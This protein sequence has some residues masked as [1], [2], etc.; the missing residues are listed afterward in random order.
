[1]RGLRGSCGIGHGR[2]AVGSVCT[3]AHALS[4]SGRG[5]G[6]GGCAGTAAMWVLVS[7]QGVWRGGMDVH[8]QG[9]STSGWNALQRALAPR[10]THVDTDVGATG[11]TVARAS[12][13]PGTRGVVIIGVD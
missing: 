11:A 12:L 7:A 8:C 2:G 4:E 5:G 9:C 3:R 1:M 6:G 10:R 13:A